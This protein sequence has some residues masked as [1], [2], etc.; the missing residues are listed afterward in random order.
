MSTSPQAPQA[1][2]S[3]PDAPEARP[4]GSAGPASGASAAAKGQT[5]LRRFP[6][7]FNETRPARPS[8]VATPLPPALYA[9]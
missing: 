1:P 5:T 8:T 7:R 9:L 6:L 4:A 3:P 2:S